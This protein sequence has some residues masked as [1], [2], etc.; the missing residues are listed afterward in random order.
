MVNILITD[1]N[2]AFKYHGLHSLK[3]IINALVLPSKMILNTDSDIHQTLYF[4]I[5]TLIGYWLSSSLPNNILVISQ[6][7]RPDTITPMAIV[8]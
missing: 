2:Y 1:M 7:P 8:S 3:K 6:F 4:G 5:T